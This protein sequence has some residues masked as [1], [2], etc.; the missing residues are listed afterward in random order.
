MTLAAL[1]PEARYVLV[2]EGGLRQAHADERGG[3]RGAQWA[4]LQDAVQEH[5][6]FTTTLRACA[7]VASEL[8]PQLRQLLHYHCGVKTLRTRQM[9]I[10]IQAL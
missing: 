10:D 1:Q 5:V 2:P 9:M 4:E 3:L 7:E 6:P 8:K